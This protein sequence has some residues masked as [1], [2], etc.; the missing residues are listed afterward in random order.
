MHITTLWMLVICATA[1]MPLWANTMVTCNADNSLSPD[2]AH[3]G[4]VLPQKMSCEELKH[5]LWPRLQTDPEPRLHRIAI[6][7]AQFQFAYGNIPILIYKTGRYETAQTQL[8][9]EVEF[10]VIHPADDCLRLNLDDSLSAA[11]L[12]QQELVLAREFSDA[13]MNIALVGLLKTIG[14]RF[15]P[16]SFEGQTWLMA[17]PP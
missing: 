8:M 12:D 13:A 3:I 17:N 10:V 5:E 14:V 2:K 16:M 4:F 7:C 15:V 9:E 11:Y 1:S 6:T